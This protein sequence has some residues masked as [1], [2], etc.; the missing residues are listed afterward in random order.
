MTHVVCDM[1]RITG[2]DKEET[3]KYLHVSEW[4]HTAAT[5]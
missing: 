2:A 4:V 5:Y 3:K 1:L